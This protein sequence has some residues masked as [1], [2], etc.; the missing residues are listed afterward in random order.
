M[1]LPVDARRWRKAFLVLVLSALG[2]IVP[3]AIEAKQ[4]RVYKVQG[5][6]VAIT[7]NQIPQLVV[8]RTPL[9]PRDHMTVGA[10][11]NAQTKVFRGRKRVALKNL[12]EGESV[13]LTYT[14][15]KTGVL[16]QLIRV[17]G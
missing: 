5:T 8:V 11:V 10:I 6:I 9:G 16:A 7:L 2:W 17:K 14:K 15:T 12:W 3:M 1:S 4:S 13:W